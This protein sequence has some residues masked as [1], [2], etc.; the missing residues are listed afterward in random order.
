MQKYNHMKLLVIVCLKEYQQIVAAILRQAKAGV[1]SAI[2]ATGF[3]GHQQDNLV[4]NWFSSGEEF[5]NSVVQ[6]S[7]TQE[8]QAAVALS[9][10]KKWNNDNQTEYPVHAFIMPVEMSSN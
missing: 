10:V 3:K 2:D 7:F 6:F 5:F 8:E 1:F 9:L 4:D